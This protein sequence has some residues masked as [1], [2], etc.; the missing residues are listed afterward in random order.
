MRGVEFL[1]KGNFGRKNHNRMKIMQ[2][3]S[4]KHKT[5]L[6]CLRHPSNQSYGFGCL[7]FIGRC[8]PQTM[9]TRI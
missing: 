1:V 2:G 3:M 7:T 6:Q 4:S 5:L 8:H 9:V